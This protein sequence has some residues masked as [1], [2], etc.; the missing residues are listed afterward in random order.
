[1]EKLTDREEEIMMI[2]WELKQAF[3]K[4]VRAQFPDPKPHINTIAT[5]IRKLENKGYLDHED[6]GSVFRFYPIISKEAYTKSQLSPKMARLFGN[7]F[8]NVVA[9]FAKE[10][11]ITKDELQ[12]IIDMIEKGEENQNK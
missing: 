5:V 12:E 4:E 8:K 6:F 1:M 10:D 11:K 9:F 3:V 2:I 7:S